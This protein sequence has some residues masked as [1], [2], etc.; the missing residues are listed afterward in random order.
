[1]VPEYGKCVSS[2]CSF[3]VKSN[4][5]FSFSEMRRLYSTNFK[6][7]FTHENSRLM[8]QILLLYLKHLKNNMREINNSSAFT[9]KEKQRVNG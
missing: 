4:I 1:M 9:E 6:K 8:R 2:V 5:D 7:A 3:S